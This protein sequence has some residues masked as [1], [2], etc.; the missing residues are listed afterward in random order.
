[1]ENSSRH[2]DHDPFP[3]ELC[4]NMLSLTVSV[5]ATYLTYRQ[6]R[7]SEKDIKLS[8]VRDEI[9]SLRLSLDDLILLLEQIKRAQKFDDAQKL[10]LSGGQVLLDGHQL[11]RFNRIDLSLTE[12]TV[13]I[14]A[15]ASRVRRQPSIEA[16]EKLSETVLTER[17]DAL[18]GCLLYTSP[19][20]R[21]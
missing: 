13:R 12:A 11:K 16:R 2:P 9:Q 7:S 15:I 21:D 5:V 10:R 4:L 3:I 19:S 6:V 1:M 17:V 14:K 8:D 18:M 20:P